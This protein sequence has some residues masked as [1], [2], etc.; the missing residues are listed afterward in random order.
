MYTKILM[1][2]CHHIFTL[3]TC[4]KPLNNYSTLNLHLPNI[5][6]KTF[7][8]EVNIIFHLNHVQES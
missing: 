3:F 6:R 1:C 7:Y 2:I 5:Q 4:F 8:K